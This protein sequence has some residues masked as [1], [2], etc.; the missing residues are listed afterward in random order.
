[1]KPLLPIL[2]LLITVTTLQAQQVVVKDS[3]VYAYNG[4]YYQPYGVNTHIINRICKDSIVQSSFGMRTLYSYN[5]LQQT[6]QVLQQFV[7]D[8]TDSFI[9][10]IGTLYTYTPAGKYDTVTLQ[11][12][13]YFGSG[14][15]R[16][17]DQYR[18]Q[19]DANN[20]LLK[21]VVYSW[22]TTD[23]SWYYSGENTYFNNSAGRLD[24]NYSYLGHDTALTIYTYYPDGR[25]Y[26]SSHYWLNGYRLFNYIATS[27]YD[28]ANYTSRD[29]TVE[30]AYAKGADTLYIEGIS[31]YTHYYDANGIQK[32]MDTYS[33]GDDGTYSSTTLIKTYYFY[34]N[35]SSVL[36]V[37]FLSFSAGR[38][39]NNAV[40]HWQTG[41]EVNTSS[42]Y[43]QRSIDG[44]H[45]INLIS[46]NASGINS[47]NLYT[48]T[49]VN[50]LLISAPK[51]YYRLAENDKDGSIHYS[52]ISSLVI[53]A[54]KGLP[55]LSP[56]PVINAFKIY[57]SVVLKDASVTISDMQGKV[58][59]SSRQNIEEGGTVVVDASRFAK[60]MYIIMVRS[61][62]YTEQLKI[63]KE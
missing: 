35:C 41:D 43:I 13:T 59:Y 21:M 44:V 37:T 25:I 14:I 60:G 7:P 19:Y 22:N 48:Y 15:L 10:S 47:G 26:Q 42:F 38:Q 20:N 2:L 4:P 1:M 33:F 46:V 29:S 31:S 23:S 11:F 17:A 63:V 9:N 27:Y 56:N 3:S 32:E 16:N 52:G 36:P 50:A 54:S 55:T 12:A 45:F 39:N 5:S 61:A 6:T 18:Y 49:D 51:L 62:S 40:L 24:S 57:S 8:N 53:S 34:G 58:V 28:S 30:E